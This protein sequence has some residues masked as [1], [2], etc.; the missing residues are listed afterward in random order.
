MAIRS[1]PTE[2]LEQQLRERDALLTLAEEAAGIGIWEIDLEAGTVRG[3]RQFWKIMGLPPVDAPVPLEI[4]RSLRLPEDR[5]RVT[6]AFARLRDAEAASLEMEYRIRRPDGEI[7]WIFGRGRLVRDPAGRP[8]QYSGI[9]IDVTERKAAETALRELTE[10]LEAR[11]EQRT[12][13]LAE[14]NDRLR[15]ERVLLERIIESAAEGIIV[16]D[17]ELRHLTWNAAMER[18]NG[19]PRGDVLGRTVFEV[20]PGFADHPVGEAWRSAISGRR[21]E[22]RDYRF[23][24]PE[25]GREI[26]YDADFT[27]LYERGAIIG[28]MCILHDTTERYRT[29]RE[30]LLYELIVEN[31]AEGIV[32]VDSDLRV[33]VWNAGVERINGLPRHAVLGKT[34]YEVFPHLRDSPVGQAWRDALTGR[35]SQMRDVAYFAPARSTE[36]VYD[37]DYTPLYD[38]AGSIIGAV[39]MVQETTER[40]R[41]Q[42]MLLQSQKLEAVAQLTGGVAH[43]FNNLLT[44]VIGCLDLIF[45]E[46]AVPRVVK[47]AETALRSANRGTRL[48][49]Q[50]LAFARRQSLRPMTADL[51]ALLGEIE[52]LLR[53]A[54]GERIEIVID[55]APELPACAIDT[56]Q[57]EAAVMN[58]VL[59]ARDAMPEGGRLT[60]R[61][62]DVPA[63]ELA[64][65]ADL[66]PGNY[67]AFTVEDT[68]EGMPPEV[69]ARAF[70]PFYTTKGASKGTGLGLSMVYGFAKQSGGGVR[71]ESASGLGTCVTLYLPHASAPAGRPDGA[72]ATDE[73]LKGCG[74]VLVVEDDSDV[75][76]VSIA[77]LEDL[78]YRVLVA[79]DGPEA[80]AVLRGADDVDLLFT[81]IAM[82]NGLSGT[83]LARLALQLRPGLRV[84]LTTGYPGS[85]DIG[86]AEF[87]VI[88]KPFRQAELSEAVAALMADRDPDAAAPAMSDQKLSHSN[89]DF[90]DRP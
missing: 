27:P 77:F 30:R 71:M 21:V 90:S 47:L 7:R 87:P 69:R 64:G 44:A 40:R 48:V 23:F 34:L 78:G 55:G 10:S 2:H 53:R 25:R 83:A 19:M 8:V 68:G 9:D 43:D 85:E 62:R 41:L 22:M 81:D 49:Q 15:R 89:G 76:D 46:A 59:N 86:D 61:T 42:E 79:R 35:R 11:I 45:Q 36:I 73:P 39:S 60:L 33:L 51:N 82:P 3:T 20:F 32:V 24:S 5:A 75:R 54:V 6:R 14:V 1:L 66:Q 13:E 88:T 16:V 37:A 28:A 12:Q 72:G 50:L 84:L 58:L 57:F 31:V 56:A 80:L 63:S 52:V 74:S 65:D 4:T 38:R 26:V 29:W 18:L 17:T 70:E 67:V